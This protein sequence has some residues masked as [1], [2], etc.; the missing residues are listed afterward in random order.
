MRLRLTTA[1]LANVR[2]AVSP[3]Q[4]IGP[5]IF[6]S[7]HPAEPAW[8]RR[9]H[10]RVIAGLSAAAEPVMRLPIGPGN[11][12]PDFLLP[13][14]KDFSPRL[15]DEIDD[16][17][18]TPAWQVERDLA[19]WSTVDPAMCA[20]VITGAR[21]SRQSLGSALRSIH[22]AAHGEDWPDVRRLLMRDVTRRIWDAGQ[23]GIDYVLDNLHPRILWRHPVLIFDL[24]VKGLPTE[25]QLAGRG[26]VL[27][28]S[29]RWSLSFNT[30]INATGP[31]VLVYPSN[32]YRP[33]SGDRSAYL[34]R[35]AKLLGRTRASVLVTVY[36]RP[37]LSTKA[38]AF[39]CGIS[40]ASASEHAAVLRDS[41]L[42]T[43]VRQGQQVAHHLTD[44][45]VR[46]VEQA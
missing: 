44:L 35:L 38:L 40:T 1:D 43:T 11:F 37:G 15:D 22:R 39:A 30:K 45:G 34:E 2:F 20:D 33:R 4:Q 27:V 31:V 24:S 18:A 19:P 14:P 29:V 46:L 3:V 10:Q 12:L 42:S 26:L 25:V 23:H 7:V 9:E 5:A 16:M 13:P 6:T 32:E 28:P 41:R 8:R 36:R 21:R 17:M